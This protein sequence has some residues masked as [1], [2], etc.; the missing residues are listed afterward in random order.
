MR[1][2]GRCLWTG[3]SLDTRLLF[4]TVVARK[5]L[6]NAVTSKVKVSK[7]LEQRFAPIKGAREKI[8]EKLLQSQ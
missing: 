5:S 3:G 7:L 1:L 6:D 4:D 8:C 2:W